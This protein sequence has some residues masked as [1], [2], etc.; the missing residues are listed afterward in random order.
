ME[1]EYRVTV[2][3]P[4]Y[5]VEPYLKDCLDSLVAQT[6]PQEDME[7]LMINDGSTD[8]SLEICEQYAEAYENFKVL[9]QENQGVSAARNNGIRSAKGKYLMY[10]DGDDTLSEETVENVIDFFDEHYDEVDLVA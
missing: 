1:F 6:I 9:S 4:V 7:V 2:I 8:G 3:I 10:L 5:N